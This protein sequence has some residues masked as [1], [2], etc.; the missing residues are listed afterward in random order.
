MYRSKGVAFLLNFLPGLGHYYAGKKKRALLYGLLFFGCLGMAFLIA[1]TSF[2]KEPAL[3]FGFVALLVGFISMVDMIVFLINTPRILSSYGRHVMQWESGGHGTG[4]GLHDTSMN[5]MGMHGVGM[6]PMPIGAAPVSGSERFATILLS[7]IPG[8]G[9]FYLGLMQRGL[10][11]LIA[12]FGLGTVLIFT[13]AITRQEGVAIFLGLLPIIWLYCMFD[14]VQAVHRKRR[15][16]VVEDRTLFDD[17]EA[18]REDGRRSKMLAMMLSVLPGAGHMYL[19][20]Q[21]RGLQLMVAFLG[22]IYV[23]DFLRLSFF[24]FVIP[25]IW[26][27]SFFDALQQISRL[28]REMLFDIPLVKSS[29]LHKRWL[30]SVLVGLGGYYLFVRLVLPILEYQ[31]NISVHFRYQIEEYLQT[32]IIA[33]VFIAGGLRL[34][35]RPSPYE[36]SSLTDL[37]IDERP[38]PGSDAMMRSRPYT[39]TNTVASERERHMHAPSGM[40]AGSKPPIKAVSTDEWPEVVTTET[41]AGMKNGTQIEGKA[42]KK[43]GINNEMEMKANDNEIQASMK[44]ETKTDSD[45]ANT[46]GREE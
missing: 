40:Q 36:S 22:A 39:P 31:F 9:H 13:A 17:Y 27:F 33:V 14:A 43:M 44:S 16:E 5:G 2:D 34:L 45:D 10:S 32:M 18:F 15:G 46:S 41:K 1:V 12:F 19:G 23:F 20:L 4:M 35:R 42:E 3:F 37:P 24:F 38:Y 21:K 29:T 7:F 11:F 6:G 8:L 25:L 28:G 30:G 26:C